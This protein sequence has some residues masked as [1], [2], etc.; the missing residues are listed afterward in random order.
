MKGEIIIGFVAAAA[1]IGIAIIIST[2]TTAL[3]VG[4][5]KITRQ[6]VSQITAQGYKNREEIEFPEGFD[7]ETF[8]PRKIIISRKVTSIG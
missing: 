4:Q 1:I 6:P 3:S 2:R 5:P 7:P 8:M